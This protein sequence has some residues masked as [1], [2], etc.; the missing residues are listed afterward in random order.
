MFNTVYCTSISCS[1]LRYRHP[2]WSRLESRLSNIP[3]TW[4]YHDGAACIGLCLTCLILA[5]GKLCTLVEN[6]CDSLVT[7]PDRVWYKR[8]DLQTLDFPLYSPKISL[9]SKK[10]VKCSPLE[11]SAVKPAEA[12][13][14]PNINKGSKLLELPLELITEILSHFVCLP[15]I[16]R[17]ICHSSFV[18][19]PR[20][21]CP[22]LERTN[23]LRALSQTCRLWR[24]LFFGSDWNLV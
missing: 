3:W 7:R 14:F 5:V 19:D 18:L 21:S 4:R 24:N 9:K 2:D 22:Y 11:N 8:T 20:V 12:P 16:T 10:R 13:A 6:C 17:K 1:A 15:I 23:V